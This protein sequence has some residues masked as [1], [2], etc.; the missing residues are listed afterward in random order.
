MTFRIGLG[1]DSH[2]IG[3]GGPMRLGGID[4]PCDFHLIGHS[5]A[6]VLLH[7][8][9]DAL[10]GAAGMD[11]IG[12]LFPDTSDENKDRD[13]AELLNLAWIKIAQQ[14]FKI[15]N[16]DCVI[17]LERPKIATYKIAIRQRIAS[18]LRIAVDQISVKGKTGEATGDIGESRLAEAHCVALLKKSIP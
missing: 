6:D 4:I 14:G 10:L 11:D 8:I 16:L 13:S 15:I 5:D 12:Q 9:T 17:R 2:R 7:A 1:I 18:V 3:P